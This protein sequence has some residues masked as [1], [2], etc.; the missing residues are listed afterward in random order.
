MQLNPS[1]ISDLIKEKIKQFEVTTEARNEGRF[2]T[3]SK[4]DTEREEARSSLGTQCSDARWTLC[5]L[6]SGLSVSVPCGAWNSWSSAIFC[7]DCAANAVTISARTAANTANFPNF[8][9][10]L[11]SL[12]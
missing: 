3:L 4:M 12:I 5:R 7:G 8:P 9:A 1:E 6:T 11:V 2:C 10:M